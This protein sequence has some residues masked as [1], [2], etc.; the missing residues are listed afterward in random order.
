MNSH[1]LY[2]N[3]KKALQWHF[4]ADF[5]FIWNGRDPSATIDQNP[6]QQYRR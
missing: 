2:I 4:Q 5:L 1:Y 6:G 3:K